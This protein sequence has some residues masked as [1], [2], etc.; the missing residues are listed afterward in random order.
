M[1]AARCLMLGGESDCHRQKCL[2]PKC[3]VA[4]MSEMKSELSSVDWLTDWT[5]F[6]VDVCLDVFLYFVRVQYFSFIAIN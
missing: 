2:S 3:P 5:T 6:L 1:C 4:V